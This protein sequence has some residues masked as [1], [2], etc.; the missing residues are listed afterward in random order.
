M[1]DVLTGETVYRHRDR[2]RDEDGR[3][4]DPQHPERKP[5]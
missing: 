2:H 4:L 1:V 5:Q 3:Y